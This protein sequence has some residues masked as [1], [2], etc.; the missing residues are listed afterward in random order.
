MNDLNIRVMGDA[1]VL[2]EVGETLD[3]SLNARVHALAR[4]L[5]QVRGVVS[6]VP[7]YTTLLL[8]YDPALCEYDALLQQILRAAESRAASSIQD[9]RLIEIPVRYGGEFGPDLEFVAQH[10]GISVEQVIAIHTRDIYQVFMLGFAPGF[11]YMGIVNEK[12]AAPRLETPRQ[13][14]PAGSVGIAGRQ[15]GIYP[16]ESPGGWRVI[17]RTDVKL[18]D[19]QSEPPTLLRA[20][21][22]VKFVNVGNS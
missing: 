17:G 16:R 15:T 2:V 20:G 6:I 13:R 11:P 21:D 5:D 18:F 8:E 14:V 3:V 12:I 4:E 9:T 22:R 7:G 1:A 19:A 10:N